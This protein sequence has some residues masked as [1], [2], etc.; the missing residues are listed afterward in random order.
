MVGLV[1]IYLIASIVPS[2]F[3]SEGISVEPAE[4]IT[5]DDSLYVSGIALREEILILAN[6][7]L[8]SVDYKVSDGD[9]V[10]KGDVVATCNV[11]DVSAGDRLAVE[12][13]DRQ[14]QLLNECISATTQYD[15]KTLDSRTKDS[16]AEYLNTFSKKDLS[17]SV[18]ASEDV[19]SH[20]IK[21]DIKATGDKSYYQKILS[22]CEASKSTILNGNSSSQSSVKASYAGYFTSQYDGYES[23]KASDYAAVSPDSIRSLISQQP[24]ERPKDYIGKLQHFSYWNFLC[25]VPE[26]NAPS[27]TEGS[28]WTLRFDTPS[29]GPRTVSMTVK[30]VSDPVDGQVAIT[31]ESSF[32]DEALYSLRMCDAQIILRSYSGF[33]VKKDSIRVLDGT[34]G[35]YVLSGAKLVFKPVTV[36]YQSEDRDFVVV[37]PKADSPSRT[38]ILNDSVIVGGKEI[39]DGKVVNI[40]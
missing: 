24:L 29:H 37:V 27:F 15:L 9:R 10:S 23:L 7:Q 20:F 39:Y 16:I 17:V 34:N 25:N 38:L 5:Y 21:R 22:N 1:L 26:S 32:F 36:L 8:S 2:I 13:I 14:I 12:S 11:G 18:E 4:G 31:F 33:R 35:V 6:K 40:N 3:S 30:S 28:F 19:V